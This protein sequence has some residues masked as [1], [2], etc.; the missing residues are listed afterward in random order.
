[1]SASGLD[2]A[3]MATPNGPG[4]PDSYYVATATDLVDRPELQESLTADVCVIGGGFTG[5]SAAL[6]LAEMGMDVV[7]LEAERIG[8]GASGRCGGL[9][10]TGQRKDVL[11]MEEAF[12]YDRSKQFWQF[13]EAAK[14]EIRMRVERHAIDCDLRW[15]FCELANTPA[16]FAAFKSEQARLADLGYEH[17]TRRVGPKDMHQIV[18]SEVYAGGLLD[19]GSG[20]LHPLKLVLGEARAAASLGVRLF[21][22]SAPS[23][24]SLTRARNDLTTA[25]LT[26]ASSRARRSAWTEIPWQAPKSSR[27]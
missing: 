17:P 21:A 20:H 6:N 13:A 23:A 11:E 24:R 25:T 26:S 12:G 19:M 8:F 7:L 16:Q 18:A 15:G 9:V 1:M 10:G 3:R 14:D 22:T 5:L 4:Y 2:I 27:P